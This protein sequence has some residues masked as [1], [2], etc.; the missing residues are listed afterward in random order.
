MSRIVP[1][2]LRRN[3]GVTNV[4]LRGAEKLQT[5]LD[6]GDG[7]LLAPNHCR[8]SDPLVMQSITREL[9]QPLFTMASSH[10]FRGG[11]LLKFLLRRGGGFSVYRE[12]FD[13][14]A[15]QKA[16][17]AL[18]TAQRPLVVFAEGSLSHANDRLNA[19]QE[20]VAFMARAAAK[21][22]AKK[23]AGGKVFVVPVALRYLFKGDL[24]AT[25]APILTDLEK[26][27][28]WRPKEHLSVL[29]RIYHVGPAL[30][31]LKEI[32][33]LGE[34]QSGVLDE[35]LDALIDHLL[36][37]LE[38]EW[39]DASREKSESVIVRVKDLRKAVMPDMIESTL[40]PDEISRR[41]QQLEDM[42][43]AQKLSLYPANYVASRHS[44]DR[45]LET[46]QRFDA[47]LSGDLRVCSPQS[48]VLE[49]GDP[50]EVSGKRDRTAV[51]DPVMAELEQQLT[52]R[53][54]ALSEECAMYQVP[55][56]GSAAS[57]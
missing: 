14:Q 40:E 34:P 53:L 27:L 51:Q 54:A 18:S 38:D 7:I 10:L 23:E 36:V 56:N 39:L 47:H 4:E 26:R 46:V 8:M 48:A 43:L 33:Y 50:I 16:I 2:V 21:K 35:R 32:E 55:E 42:E 13:R 9:D 17:D 28:S 19:L 5:L 52:T 37:P 29:D 25:A 57:A 45:I 20:G 1:T 3:Y 41:W 22:R 31:T 30:L 12:G 24:E 15:L 6:A 49:I 44:V 11:G